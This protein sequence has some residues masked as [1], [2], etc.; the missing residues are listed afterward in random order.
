[1]VIVGEGVVVVDRTD[2]SGGGEIKGWSE[3]WS[4]RLITPHECQ[5]GSGVQSSASCNQSQFPNTQPPAAVTIVQKQNKNRF[6]TML[7]C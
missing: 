7:L 5:V 1:M 4:S 6:K 3:V 2:V